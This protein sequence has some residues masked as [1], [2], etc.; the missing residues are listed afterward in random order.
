MS[1]MPI[2]LPLF[3]VSCVAVCGWLSPNILYLPYKFIMLIYLLTRCSSLGVSVTFYVSTRLKLPMNFD[4][5]SFVH[6]KH[7][8]LAAQF[9]VNGADPKT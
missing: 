8:S 4:A 9:V 1:A 5:C 3:L 7:F 6:S 2:F